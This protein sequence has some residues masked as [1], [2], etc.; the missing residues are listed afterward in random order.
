MNT[1]SSEQRAVVVAALRQLADLIEGDE[2]LPVPFFGQLQC[3]A[4]WNL[5]QAG[6]FAA[7]RAFADR[8][9]LDVIE[10]EQGGRRAGKQV[11]PVEYFI[12]ANADEF[13]STQER[14]V[15]A[16]EDA[17]PTAGTGVA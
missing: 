4:P 5:P 12:L 11:G 6:R 2:T 17:A 8:L 3:S 1:N 15:P 16:S 7:V 9:G 13:A 14:I 10:T